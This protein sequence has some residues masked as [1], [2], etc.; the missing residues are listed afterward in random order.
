MSAN[1]TIRHVDII[2]V[3]FIG[4]LYWRIVVYSLA[5]K[6]RYILP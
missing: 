2:M 1:C 4:K 6:F 5:D 3:E